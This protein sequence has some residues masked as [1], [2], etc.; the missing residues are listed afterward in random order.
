MKNIL[1]TLLFNLFD[2]SFNLWRLFAY[3]KTR[4][5]KIIGAINVQPYNA[6]HNQLEMILIHIDA[7]FVFSASIVE[8]GLKTK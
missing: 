8:F 7:A 4:F 2:E 3:W 5:G 6:M 1:S